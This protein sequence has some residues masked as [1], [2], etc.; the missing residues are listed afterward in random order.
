MIRV[1]ELEK[2]I[3]DP[4]FQNALRAA[5]KDALLA[6]IRELQD[7]LQDPFVYR[8]VVFALGVV[9]LLAIGGAIYLAAQPK[10]IPDALVAL[11]SAAIGALAGLIAPKQG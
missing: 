10:E 1:R 3:D 4:N 5:P 9:G 7:P 6:A 2:K 11:G 8:W